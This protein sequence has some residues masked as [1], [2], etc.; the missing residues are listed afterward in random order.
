MNG[1]MYGSAAPE[2]LVNEVGG[3][4]GE[5]RLGGLRPRVCAS[6]RWIVRSCA[7]RRYQAPAFW[8]RVTVHI[9]VSRSVVSMAVSSSS[10]L[11]R[12]QR[13]SESFESGLSW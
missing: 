5:D 9:V 4:L 10:R 8:S 1:T 13:A 12:Y 7:W 2:Q 3:A 6:Q 11:V